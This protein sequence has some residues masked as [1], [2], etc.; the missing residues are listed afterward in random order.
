M[1]RQD[2]RR[3]ML[4][5]A[6][7]LALAGLHLRGDLA[8]LQVDR[9]VPNAD[10]AH[11]RLLC[12]QC[13]RVFAE[14]WLPELP[15][16]LAALDVAYPPLAHIVGAAFHGAV[17]RGR[18]WVVLAG[19]FWL[20][21]LLAGSYG[22]AERLGGPGCGPA[23][24]L[25][26]AA[27]PM[28]YA[29]SRFLMLELPVAALAVLATLALECSGGL[30]SLG[31]A[32]LLGVACG[33]GLLTKYTFPIFL[34]GPLLT[35]GWA[36]LGRPGQRVRALAK[37]AS[38]LLVATAVAAAISGWWYAVRWSERTDWLRHSESMEEQ[39][40]PTSWRDPL[41][42]AYYGLAALSF[43]GMPFCLLAAA[44]G[45]TALARRRD[46]A[47][48][49]LAVWTAVP[50]AILTAIRIKWGDYFLAALPPLALA[51]ALGY[52]RPSGSTDSN[53]TPRE[54]SLLRPAKLFAAAIAGAVLWWPVTF[55]IDLVRPAGQ[56]H[57]WAVE[58]LLLG[59]GR[60]VRKLVLQ[61]P[62][63]ADAGL[64]KFDWWGHVGAAYPMAEVVDA[65]A[66]C[67]DG[68]RVGVQSD[69]VL[70]AD[71]ETLELAAFDAELSQRFTGVSET[72]A[73]RAEDLG[74]LVLHRKGPLLPDE[75]SFYQLASEVFPEV[76]LPP[77]G[78]GPPAYF[79][80]LRRI[81]SLGCMIHVYRRK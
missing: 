15:R 70:F 26:V 14:A 3:L 12:L 11:H 41:G 62:E 10:D 45:G 17:P 79:C 30:Q 47:A 50:Y 65:I 8:W 6:V 19:C 78:D 67:P 32:L 36:A 55:G 29:Q 66:G 71:R 46:P 49:K 77:P 27:F 38:S 40:Y 74:G 39:S 2:L 28:V 9:G 60:L 81:P 4:G 20:L 35:A 18:D 34:A 44:C 25:A 43:P 23:A 72:G 37:A 16:R 73:Y 22:L 56:L 51:A 52:E 64:F 59:P 76:T 21:V 33:L 1:T 48:A 54:S 7:C 53:A 75:A 68:V 31:A 58:N 61:V 80:I 24:A 57:S 42:V 63:G 13:E 69:L 5:S